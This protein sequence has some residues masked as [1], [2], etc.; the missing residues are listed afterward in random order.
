MSSQ[1][2]E[3]EAKFDNC[4]DGKRAWTNMY[5]GKVKNAIDSEDSQILVAEIEEEVVGFSLG[6]RME[7]PMKD[8]FY[9]D[10]LFVKEAFRDKGIGTKLLQEME[11]F[12]AEYGYK[13]IYIGAFTENIGA[14]NLHKK[15]GFQD[16]TLILEKKLK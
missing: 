12:A 8:A 1:F 7:P 9:I 2:S 15:L 14:I 5:K 4:F 11:K 3:I 6:K 16:N 13:K 10:S